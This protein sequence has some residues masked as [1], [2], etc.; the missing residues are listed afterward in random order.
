MCLCVTTLLFYMFMYVQV[1]TYKHMVW[2]NSS[3][4]CICLCVTSL[5]IHVCV[6]TSIL[7]D[8]SPYVFI[9]VYMCPPSP[10]VCMCLCNLYLI[11]HDCVSMYDHSFIF[12]HVYMCASTCI[13]K[14]YF[15]V[16]M[17]ETS[18]SNQPHIFQEVQ[19]TQRGVVE[20][21]KKHQNL[22]RMI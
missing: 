9:C 8:L 19:C 18:P 17:V 7:C 14:S 11:L 13:Y 6:C 22:F 3:C 4:V 1:C 20:P 21:H 16:I 15:W 5:I 10:Y 2:F 12:V